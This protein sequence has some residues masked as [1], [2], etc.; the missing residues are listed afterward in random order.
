MNKGEENFFSGYVIGG[1]MV[2]LFVCFF[3][4]P[5]WITSIL[6]LGGL[7]F[8]MKIIPKEI[9]EKHNETMSPI[10]LHNS[11]MRTLDEEE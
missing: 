10:D 9:E 2:L 11:I 7:F 6:L 4:L 5:E 1:C 3:T 8:F